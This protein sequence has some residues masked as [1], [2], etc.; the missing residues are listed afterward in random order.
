MKLDDRLAN[1]IKVLSTV[2][3]TGAIA[4]ELWNLYT[5]GFEQFDRFQPLIGFERFALLA[6]LGEGA[7]AAFYAPRKGEKPIRFAIYTF[8]VG[9]IGLFELF[10]RS[11]DSNESI[12]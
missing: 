1:G 8:F 2:L 9:T 7:I 12:G 3:I 6:H 5:H 4:L 10:D 11:S